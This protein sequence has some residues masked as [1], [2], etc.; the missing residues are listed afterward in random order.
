MMDAHLQEKEVTKFWERLEK[1]PIV[2]LTDTFSS[3]LRSRP[4][5]ARIRATENAIWFF[6][7]CDCIFN[8]AREK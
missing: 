2:M 8:I 6:Y 3:G 7:R 4:M 5:A 1:Q